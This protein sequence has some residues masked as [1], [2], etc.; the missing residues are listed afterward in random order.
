[1]HATVVNSTQQCYNRFMAQQQTCILAKHEVEIF[2]SASVMHDG[3]IVISRAQICSILLLHLP[4]L[5][6]HH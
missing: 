3:G 4:K 5:T 2:R 1:M 6:F